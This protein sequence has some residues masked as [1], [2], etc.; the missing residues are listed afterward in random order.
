MDCAISK[1]AGELQCLS[2]AAMFDTETVHVRQVGCY[3]LHEFLVAVEG[4]S[5]FRIS[6]VTG[7]EF[8]VYRGHKRIFDYVENTCLTCANIVEA[9]I[10]SEVYNVGGKE[11]LS[12]SIEGLADVMLQ[13]VGASPSLAMYK[14]EEGLTTQF[15]IVDFSKSRRDLEHHPKIDIYEGVRRYISWVRKMISPNSGE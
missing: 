1:W 15:K 13:T 7:R 12:I 9:F 5:D 4:N 14:G 3:G 8:A 10:T 11:E 6:R 2:H